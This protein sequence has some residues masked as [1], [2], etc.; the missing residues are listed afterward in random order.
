M[1]IFNEAGAGYGFAVPGMDEEEAETWAS[2]Y[3]VIY[4]FA[5]NTY[6]EAP[7]PIFLAPGSCVSVNVDR[8]EI[9]T[10]DRAYTNH[11][12]LHKLSEEFNAIPRWLVWGYVW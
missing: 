1:G 8:G 12:G 5:G 4:D 10:M 9:K 3:G 7:T 2:K 11:K 6:A